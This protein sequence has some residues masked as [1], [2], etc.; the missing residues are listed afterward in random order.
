[1]TRR[2]AI[3]RTDLTGLA[4]CA[5]RI[6]H[7]TSPKAVVRSARFELG[8]VHANG[9]PDGAA[10]GTF[11]ATVAGGQAD[12]VATDILDRDAGCFEAKPSATIAVVE[13]RPA[14]I[15]TR[16]TRRARTP[17]VP[18]VGK[19]TA[20]GDGDPH[21]VVADADGRA[22]HVAG[23]HRQSVSRQPR[24]LYLPHVRE[25]IDAGGV[26][27]C[28]GAGAGG[29]TTVATDGGQFERALVTYNQSPEA[30]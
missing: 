19:G 21:P 1:M 24:S 11:L 4:R 28:F 22:Q 30:L 12:F 23:R 7:T 5:F 10:V 27:A 6:F 2:A 13:A 9:N 15:G 26:G 3:W 14:G 20:Q 17:R 29:Q 8:S 16:R 18:V 25:F